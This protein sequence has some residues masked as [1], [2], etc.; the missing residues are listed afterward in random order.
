[1][2]KIDLSEYDLNE[3]EADKALNRAEKKKKRK[4][5]SSGKS[6]QNSSS[7]NSDDD[8]SSALFW[9]VMG[10][11]MLLLYGADASSILF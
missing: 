1:M 11:S 6:S 2:A 10:I 4:S 9:I 5:G 7:S 8:D 3:E